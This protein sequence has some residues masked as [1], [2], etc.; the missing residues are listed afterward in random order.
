MDSPFLWAEPG[1]LTKVH[2]RHRNC[3]QP[4]SLVC[5][6]FQFCR[7]LKAGGFMG[8]R[9]AWSVTWLCFAFQTRSVSSCQELHGLC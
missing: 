3:P 7:L 9:K 8:K 6:H 4:R 2:P 5:F 1:D